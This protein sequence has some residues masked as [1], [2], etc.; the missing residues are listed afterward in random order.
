MLR[1]SRACYSRCTQHQDNNLLKCATRLLRPVL[2]LIQQN[3]STFR[4]LLYLLLL[5]NLSRRP[6]GW[7]ARLLTGRESQGRWAAYDAL[8]LDMGAYLVPG[9]PQPHS[10]RHSYDG[11]SPCGSRMTAARGQ[12]ALRIV[13][14][15]PQRCV[16]VQ[17]GGRCRRCAAVAQLALRMLSL[18]LRAVKIERKY[19]ATIC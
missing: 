5:R 18:A 14:L 9:L 13:Q 19:L 11:G 12:H 2:P 17:R 16:A 7:L 4:L 3:R 8:A 10:A 1:R 6:K 15:L